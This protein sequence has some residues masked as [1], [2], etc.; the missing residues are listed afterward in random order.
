MNT[1]FILHSIKEKIE[2]IMQKINFRKGFTRIELIIVVGV[3]AIIIGVGIVMWLK[4]KSERSP[5]EPAFFTNTPQRTTDS[6]SPMILLNAQNNSGLNAKYQLTAVGSSSGISSQT[7]VVLIA[8]NAS[9]GVSMPAH[10]HSGSC[11]NLGAVKY[12]LSNLINGASTTTINASI[13]QL[14]LDLPLAI[15][16]HKSVTEAG[17]Y[18][19]C[20]DLNADGSI[21]RLYN[22][23]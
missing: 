19:A 23:N 15:N 17:I 5:I 20:A 18:V 3:V 12:P 10:I 1:R 4:I 8:N 16:I 22:G 14:K 6:S 2:S 11:A 7:K 9:Q 21:D 13:L